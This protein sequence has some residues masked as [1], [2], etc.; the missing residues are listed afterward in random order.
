M[1]NIV[2]E[3]PP[4][5]APVTP[6]E[7]ETAAEF[8]YVPIDLIQTAPQ[9]RRDI[10]PEGESIRSLAGTIRE[11]GMMQPLGV[12]RSGEG[13][14]LVTGERRLLA[15]R[16]L[17]LEKVPVRVLEGV[18]RQEDILTCQLIENLQRED[19]DPIE[20][21]EGLLALYQARQG[22]VSLEEILNVLQTYDRDPARVP[23]A[24]AA[25]VAAIVNIS[26]KS[27][28]SLRRVF[29]LLRL[30]DQI[31]NALR[32]DQ[33]GVS[34]GYLLA[35]FVD[36]PE[37]LTIFNN[38]LT[39]PVTNEALKKQLEAY[40]TSSAG[41]RPRAYRPFQGIYLSIKNAG[42]TVGDA[43]APVT[44]ADLTKLL[45][46]LKALAAQVETRLQA[47]PSDEIPAAGI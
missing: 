17:G 20:T 30:P 23:E 9:I 6:E 38:L 8:I 47:F 3:L 5:P 27:E 12:V 29:S 32:R 35:E 2:E 16:L 39:T 7:D 41:G 33:I 19:L 28:R 46:E 11:R 1:V 43:S 44:K 26:G 18:D 4:A 15:A 25:T 22:N 40:K 45:E 42:A 21:A 31:K 10:D 24:L 34:H 37:L 36:N 14:L 13:Y